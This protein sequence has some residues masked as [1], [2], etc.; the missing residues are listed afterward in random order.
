VKIGRWRVVAGSIARNGD[1]NSYPNRYRNFHF[2][3]FGAFGWPF[4]VGYFCPLSQFL[5]WAAV[6]VADANPLGPDEELA[7]VSAH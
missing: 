3:R 6:A 7:E 5:C 1:F 2:S 4:F